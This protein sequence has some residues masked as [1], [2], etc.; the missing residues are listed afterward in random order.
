MTAIA[1]LVVAE[2]PRLAV[3]ELGGVDE[4][5]D[6]PYGDGSGRRTAVH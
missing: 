6:Q 2:L 4:P 3:G 5:G 1:A